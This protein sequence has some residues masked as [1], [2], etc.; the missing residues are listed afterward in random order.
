M[1]TQ[2][3]ANGES[4][5]QRARELGLPTSAVEMR[6]YTRDGSIPVQISV[7]QQTADFFWSPERG[8]V[9]NRCLFLTEKQAIDEARKYA[10][11]AE[12]RWQ[13]TIDTLDKR[14][15]AIEDA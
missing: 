1:S 5:I 2:T 7:S 12:A 3:P 4:R 13:E 9:P 8:D 15:D 14:Y 11:A 6:W 10:L